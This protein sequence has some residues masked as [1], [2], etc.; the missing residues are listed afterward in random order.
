MSF[1]PKKFTSPEYFIENSWLN[2]DGFLNLS[3]FYVN[4]IRMPSI[5]LPISSDEL[6]DNL[7]KID[8]P[9]INLGVDVSKLSVVVKDR[10][11]GSDL[12]MTFWE[13]SNMKVRDSFSIWMNSIVD[14]RDELASVNR[15][16][17]D[18]VSSDIEVIPINGVGDIINKKD[19]FVGVIPTS[20]SGSNFD[21]AENEFGTVTIG[22][23]ARFHRI[24]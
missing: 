15:N 18:D 13:E 2:G 7:I 14:R 3:R 5:A 19:V 22:F 8:L 16:Y 10:N 9:G 20:I 4:F 11:I 23:K 12:S 24:E 21:Y 1:D 6:R 17:F